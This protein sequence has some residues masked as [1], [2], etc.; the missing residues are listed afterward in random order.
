[1]RCDAR[2]TLKYRYRR[3]YRI[4]S[5]LPLIIFSEA[6]STL[7]S[8]QISHCFINCV[9]QSR[10]CLPRLEEMRWEY[11]MC[12]CARQSDIISKPFGC[13]R[14]R[15]T[16]WIPLTINGILS[17]GYRRAHRKPSEIR[18][19]Y[20]KAIRTERRETQ[21]RETGAAN[22]MA[23]R[24]SVAIG[25]MCILRCSHQAH[26]IQVYTHTL[27]TPDAPSYIFL[28]KFTAINFPAST[29][30]SVLF[31]SFVFFWLLHSLSIVH[32]HHHHYRHATVIVCSF[33][34]KFD[35][36][37]IRVQLYPLD[38]DSRS[39]AEYFRCTSRDANEN[40]NDGVPLR[41]D[42]CELEQC[43]RKWER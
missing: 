36:N 27:L 19:R 20:Q 41:L 40:Q 2:S 8:I 5:Q 13:E 3:R 17:I 26:Q 35:S 34:S 21:D 31:L 6:V 39:F 33:S 24:I 38:E 4:I 11:S 14:M 32:H 9:V 22:G 23:C 25:E 30:S 43:A 18:W 37:A 42:R 12:V 7:S 10:I 1:M 16:K 15:R 29:I 28:R